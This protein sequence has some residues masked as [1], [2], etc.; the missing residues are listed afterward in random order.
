MTVRCMS[1]GGDSVA[2]GRFG[3]QHKTG[4]RLMQRRLR[5]QLEAQLVTG[6]AAKREGFGGA[7]NKNVRID[8]VDVASRVTH[9]TGSPGRKRNNQDDGSK[10]RNL[11]RKR[12]SSERKDENVEIAQRMPEGPNDQ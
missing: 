6:K 3:V 7:R 9:N 5:T 12:Q 4:S 8:P 10:K 11:C 2:A 1:R